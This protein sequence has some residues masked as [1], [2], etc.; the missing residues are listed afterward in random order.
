MI[1]TDKFIGKKFTVSNN[2]LPVI[3]STE[4]IEREG[5][6]DWLDGVRAED[7]KNREDGI[8]PFQYELFI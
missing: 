3:E 2:L 8:E 1:E 7:K 4:Y 5:I 6:L